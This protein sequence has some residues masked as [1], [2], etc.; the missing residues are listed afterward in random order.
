[1]FS[2]GLETGTWLGIKC[3]LIHVQAYA[4]SPTEHPVLGHE[5]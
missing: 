3:V 4:G 2:A 1:M 5:Q